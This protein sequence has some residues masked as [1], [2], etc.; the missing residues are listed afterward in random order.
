MLHLLNYKL[1][2]K[3][4]ISVSLTEPFHCDNFLNT[5]EGVCSFFWRQEYHRFSPRRKSL[6]PFLVIENSLIL[7]A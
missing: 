1:K 5:Y 2:S 4:K 6:T 7:L 3:K